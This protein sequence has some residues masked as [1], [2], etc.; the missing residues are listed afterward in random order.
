MLAGPLAR[1]TPTLSK[2]GGVSYLPEAQA[3]FARMTTQPDATRKGLINTLIGDLISAGVWSKMDALY[4]LAAHDA[5]AARLNFI[6]DQF[7]LTAV[8]SPAFTVDRGYQGDGVSTFL[9]TSFSPTTAVSPKFVQNSGHIMFWSRTAASSGNVDMGNGNTIIATRLA[10]DLAAHRVNAASSSNSTETDGSGC[11]VSS[12]TGSLAADN[13]LYRNGTSRATGIGSS[14]PDSG[15]M[16]VLGRSTTVSFSS[17]QSAAASI[18]GGLTAGEVSSL[19]TSLNTYLQ[20]I[21]AA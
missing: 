21:G 10:G 11:Y 16:R 5:Q 3:L 19:Y 12:R 9:Q 2:G 7:N 6:A 1:R 14:A 18:G 13:T 15:T 8:S 17:R 20:A 4:V